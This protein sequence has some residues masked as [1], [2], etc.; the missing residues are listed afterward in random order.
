MFLDSEEQIENAIRYVEENPE[1]EG[2]PRQHW[3]FVSPF[4]GLEVGGRPWFSVWSLSVGSFFAWP[5]ATG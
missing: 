1:E 3:R 4:R 2:K 5:L